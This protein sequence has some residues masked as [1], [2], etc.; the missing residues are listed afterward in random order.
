M[1]PGVALSMI[2]MFI[3]CWYVVPQLGFLFEYYLYVSAGYAVNRAWIA[4]VSRIPDGQQMSDA[5][6]VYFRT[7]CGASFSGWLLNHMC[8]IGSN[9]RRQMF[10][11]TFV[12]H[13]FGLSRD[14][15][16]ILSN[17]GYGVTL[18][19]FDTLRKMYS[20]GSSGLSR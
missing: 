2:C 18:D 7:Q 6:Q 10:Y 11:I 13:Y 9:G 17:Y 14:G 19:M 12:L 8:S 1:L 16:T 3:D 5:R 20:A 15:I 4:D